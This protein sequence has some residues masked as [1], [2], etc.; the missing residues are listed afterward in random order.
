MTNALVA[1]PG[2]FYIR[3]L[4]CAATA[5]VGRLDPWVCPRNPYHRLHVK[6]L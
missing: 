1:S 4:V 3:C 2:S 5:V 6:E